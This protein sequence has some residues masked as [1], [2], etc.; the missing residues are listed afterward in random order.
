MSSSFQH[1]APGSF[2]AWAPLCSSG[3]QTEM[4]VP[5]ASVKIAMRPWSRTA[6]SGITTDP[7]AASTLSVVVAMSSTET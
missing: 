3:C 6:M 2:T 5:V 1:S 4:N 7:P